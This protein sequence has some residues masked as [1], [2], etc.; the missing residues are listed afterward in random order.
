M[1]NFELTPTTQVDTVW[2]LCGPGM[3][4]DWMAMVMRDTPES[5]W[6]LRYRF[7]YYS[8]ES[9]GRDPHD[10]RDTFSC[11]EVRSKD[12]HDPAMPGA[13]VDAA[14]H[15]A[16]ILMTA[17]FGGELHRKPVHGGVDEFAAMMAQQSWSSMREERVH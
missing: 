17:G 6:Y 8:P 14:E 9:E 3:E 11:Y 2:F 4:Q 5:P 1:A 10:H 7:R 16:A 12:P 15:L 13:L